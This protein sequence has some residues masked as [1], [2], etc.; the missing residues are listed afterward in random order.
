MK[1]LFSKAISGSERTQV[2]KKNI[3]GSFLIKGLSIVTSFV[4]IPLTIK[5]LDPEKYGIWMTIFSIVT[6]FNMMDIGIGNGFRNKFADALARGDKALAREYVQTFYSVMALISGGIFL[7]ISVVNPF[8]NW[9]H[10]LNI[11]SGFNENIGLIIWM[12]F[13]LFSVQLFLKNISTILLSLQKTTYSNFILFLGNVLALLAIL[14]LHKLNMISLFTVALS[15][16]LAPISVFIV[17]TFLIFFGSLKE[18]RPKLFV[19]PQQKF[20]KDLVGLGL[21]F[22]FIQIAGIVMFSSDNIIISQLFGPAEVTPYNVAF[23]LFFAM[24]TFFTIIITPFWSAFT[25]ANARKDFKWIRDSIKNLLMVWGGFA[26]LVMLVVL[27]SPFLYRVW[28]GKEINIPMGM[29]FQ[30]AIF[31]LLSTWCNLFVFYINGV[32][33][34]R[35]QLYSA[36]FQCFAN[37]PLAIFLAKFLHLGPTGVI[38]SINLNMMIPAIL[39]PLQYKKLINNTAKGIWSR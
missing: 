30:F 22:F 37:I 39:M 20:L 25:E 10:I 19:L 16:M 32:G 15:F 31:T 35:L 7:L 5:M 34:I 26:A 3:L 14:V 4:L 36:T 23:R 21:K 2:V 12:V 24:Q 13:L 28:I 38:L 27:I 9:Y 29:S 11:P 17:V 18:Y 33:K 6:W 8:L 1:R